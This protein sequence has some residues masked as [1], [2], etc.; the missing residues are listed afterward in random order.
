MTF[1]G[2]G[3]HDTRGISILVSSART[4]QLKRYCR[5]VRGGLT[6]PPSGDLALQAVGRN[7]VDAAID[8][9]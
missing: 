7:A 4:L 3:G 1:P 5:D 2:A 9:E 8:L 6:H